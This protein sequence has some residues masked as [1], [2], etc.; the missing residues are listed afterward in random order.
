VIDLPERSRDS[1][2]SRRSFMLGGVLLSA[3]AASELLRPRHYLADSSRSLALETDVPKSFGTWAVD[4][5]IIPV[6]PDLSVQEKLDELYSQ[7]LARTYVNG[8]GQRVMLSIAYGSDQSSEVTSVHR[9][10]FCY[11]AQG[12]LVRTVGTQRLQIQQRSLLVEQLLATA[13]PRFEPIIYWIT[14]GTKALLPGWQRRV[15]QLR[16]G[17]HGDIPDGMLVRTSTVGIE[18]APSFAIQGQFLRS[19]NAALTQDVRDRIFG[20]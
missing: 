2:D 7:V 13:G 12:F 17:L 18:Q 16:Y 11:R 5:S 15:E 6:L 10:E 14:L 8:A 1:L 3:L 19:M 20:K 4:N 9:P